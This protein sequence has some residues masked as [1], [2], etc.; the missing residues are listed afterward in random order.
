M[1]EKILRRSLY[2]KNALMTGIRMR[3]EYRWSSSD[4]DTN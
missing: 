2:M 1:R 4:N 3:W